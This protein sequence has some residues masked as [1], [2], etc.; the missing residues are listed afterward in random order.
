MVF[1]RTGARTYAFQA[2]LPN[3]RYKQLPTGAPFTAGGKGLAQRMAAMWE[4]LATEHRAWD[5]LEPVLTAGRR[6]R[7]ARLGRLYDLWV[8]TRYNVLEM[9]RLLSDV[10]LEPLVA[11]WHDAHRRSVGT[12]HAS[13]LI[14]RLRWLLP[15]GDACALSKVTTAWLTER[16][17]AYPGKRNTLRRVHSA[18]SGFFEY[19]TRVHG[20]FP[21][22]PMI[23]VTRAV[24]RTFPDPVL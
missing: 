17:A 5:L 6:E 20:H 23:A 21:V 15:A 16:L 11:L 22:N 12:I 13:Q 19:A 24:G 18:W 14:A 2:R 10:D 8:S 4:S 9:R 7:A 3:G 1:R